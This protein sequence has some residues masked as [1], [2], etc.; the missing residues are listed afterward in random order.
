MT[1]IIS[2]ILVYKP[3]TEQFAEAQ[4]QVAEI[5]TQTKMEKSLKMKKI[6]L[7]RYSKIAIFTLLFFIIFLKCAPEGTTTEVFNWFKFEKKQTTST[8]PKTPDTKPILSTNKT[9][10]VNA[11]ILINGGVPAIGEILYLIPTQIVFQ[12][13]CLGDKKRSSS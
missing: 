10:H 12:K 8:I 9:L 11:P 5:A 13:V 6:T 1:K 7:S 2:T 3:K 4:N